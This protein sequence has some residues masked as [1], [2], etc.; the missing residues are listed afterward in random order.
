M[1]R[2]PRRTVRRISGSEDHLRINSLFN[3]LRKRGPASISF[4]A[5]FHA[6][7]SPEIGSKEQVALWLRDE[8]KKVRKSETGNALSR[9]EIADAAMTMIE[10]WLGLRDLTCDLPPDGSGVNL[11]GL[12][13]ELLDVDR[14]RAALAEKSGRLEYCALTEAVATCC[15]GEHLSDNELAQRCGVSRVTVLNWRRSAAYRRELEIALACCA[16]AKNES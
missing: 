9:I 10:R 1:S 15:Y 5:L 3:L 8:L 7:R 4:D 2:K 12:L 13:R 6:L 11:L 16:E 14:H